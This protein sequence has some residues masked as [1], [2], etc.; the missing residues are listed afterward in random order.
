MIII[1]YFAVNPLEPTNGLTLKSTADLRLE[2]WIVTYAMT[3]TL[4][5]SQFQGS[6]RKVNFPMQN[7]RAKILTRDS[8]V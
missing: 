7:P 5:S 6:L 2:E 8:N 3:M 1:H 4:K